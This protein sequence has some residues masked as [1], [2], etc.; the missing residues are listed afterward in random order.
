MRGPAPFLMRILVLLVSLCTLG[1]IAVASGQ[2]ADDE[3]RYLSE[4][5][6]ITYSTDLGDPDAPDLTDGDSD[7][8]PDSIERLA[9]AFESVYAF[10]VDEL[11]F[12]PP[13]GDE[14]Y[15][16]YV[17]V[18]GDVPHIRVIPGDE[19][20]SRGSF[21]LVPP[22]QIRAAV[23]QAHLES[24]VAH[25]FFHA[26]Q[27]GYDYSESKWF[28]EASA[29]IMAQTMHPELDVHYW[30]LPAFLT[31]LD[32]GLIP[33]DGPREYGAFLYLR[34]LQEGWGIGE[35]L[36][37]VFLEVFTG[38]EGTERTIESELEA[39]LNEQNTTSA[40]AWAG[41]IFWTRQLSLFVDGADY[42]EALAGSGYLKVPKRKV[43]GE[44][45]RIPTPGGAVWSSV[46][47]RVR[48]KWSMSDTTIRMVGPPDAKMLVYLKEDIG[49]SAVVVD[50][51]DDGVAVLDVTPEMTL[52]PFIVFT[53]A[54]ATE[55][56][57]AYSVRAAEGASE[58]TPGSPSGPAF[59]VFGDEAT[60]RGSVT[61][62]GSPAPFASAELIVQSA[63][64]ST[65][66]IE[67]ITDDEGR[68]TTELIPEMDAAYRIRVTDPLLSE[69]FSPS[70]GLLVK[71]DVTLVTDRGPD[72]SVLL[73]GMVTPDAS[74]ASLLVQYRRPEAA[75][76]RTGPTVMAEEGGTYAVDLELP[77]DGVWEMRVVVTEDDDPY[78]QPGMSS[79]EVVRIRG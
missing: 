17:V 12:R 66:V 51:G 38:A 8:M 70:T 42:R 29:V 43:E 14:L 33:T 46:G 55:G 61:C 24:L 35:S 47:E 63:D 41:F 67:L 45:C 1:P 68:W 53:I 36:P 50:V 16:V 65:S 26:I 79:I 6:A 28:L 77:A 34:Y 9:D 32:R 64:G 69:A 78:R 31:T 37:A 4:H 5:F 74:G 10:E 23:T 13:P 71:Q 54:T 11:G 3:D 58:V 44:S 72:R 20:T 60:L 27:Y 15:E 39:L 40:D 62:D 59:T 7:G 56:E 22:H 75:R 48:L 19:G 52:R 25:E 73:S 30:T 21:I 49:P 57:L 18:G 76:W 2:A